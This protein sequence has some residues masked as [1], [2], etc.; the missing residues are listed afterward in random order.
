MYVNRYGAGQIDYQA[1]YVP[2]PK[3]TT[4]SFR[5]G[6]RFGGAEI[7]DPYELFREQSTVFSNPYDTGHEF[8]T[9]KQI[10]QTSHREVYL[11]GKGA[12]STARYRGPLWIASGNGGI[13]S[14]ESPPEISLQVYGTKAISATRPN[15]PIASPAQDLAEIVREG[16]PKFVGGSVL[17]PAFHGSKDWRAGV[18]RSGDEFLNWN[19]G[20]LPTISM[21]VDAVNVVLKSYDTLAQFIRDSERVV[22]RQHSFDPI[23]DTSFVVDSSSYPFEIPDTGNGGWGTEFSRA[24]MGWKVNRSLRRDIR[25]SGAYTYFVNKK[26]KDPLSE[27]DRYRQLARKLVNVEITLDVVWALTPWS[28]LI[29]WFVDFG[30]VL[31]NAVAFSQDGLVLRYGYIM[32][33]STLDRVSTIDKLL[34]NGDSMGPLSTTYRTV[35]KERLKASPFGF[36]IQPAQFSAQQWAILGALG[37]TKGSNLLR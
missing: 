6:P 7:T 1:A 4:T 16:F 34:I 13:T 26:G 21:I 23:I 8:R 27:L 36:G 17:K 18:K 31:T 24:T 9:E 12:Y 37:M 33:E 5:S 3:Q 32:C 10:L 29:D 11:V 19:F 28:W 35:R 14:F 30:D 2:V 15:R 22:R 20:V 25:F